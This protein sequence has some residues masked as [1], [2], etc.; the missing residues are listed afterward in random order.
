MVQRSVSWCSGIALTATILPAPNDGRQTD[1]LFLPSL[2]EQSLRECD[3]LDGMLH[4]VRNNRSTAAVEA[5]CVLPAD[6]L[7][8]GKGLN[9]KGTPMGERRASGGNG[10]RPV[11]AGSRRLRSSSLILT[12]ALRSR[13]APPTSLIGPKYVYDDDLRSCWERGQSLVVYHHVGRTYRGRKAEARE[14]IRSRCRDLRQR[15]AGAKPIALRWQRSS[16][17]VFFVLPSPEHAVRL[18]AR[19]GALLSSPWAADNPPRFELVDC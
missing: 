12:T 5:N 18:K 15:L 2:H 10:S 11:C 8:F 16:P 13:A 1:Y 14:Q 7:F 4:L 3:L 19:I 9:F 17:R 6:T